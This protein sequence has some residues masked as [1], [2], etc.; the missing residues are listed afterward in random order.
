MLYDK[1]LRLAHAEPETRAALVPLLRQAKGLAKTP[2][3]AKALYQKYKEKHPNTKKGPSDFYEAPAEG[4][5]RRDKT[6][7]ERSKQDEGADKAK[8]VEKKRDR[9]Q[10]REETGPAWGGAGRKR[11]ESR[12]REQA[13]AFLKDADPA[14]VKSEATKILKDM[15][16][17]AADIDEAIAEAAKGGTAQRAYAHSVLQKFKKSLSDK[18]DTA[19]RKTKLKGLADKHGISDKGV[20]SLRSWVK[21][22]PDQSTSEKDKK[23]YWE[24]RPQ[25]NS[26]SDADR[27]RFEKIDKALNFSKK[28]SLADK[29]RDFMQHTDPETRQRILK[30]SPKEF[31]AM[32]AAVM[33]DEEGGG[34]QARV[35]SVTSDWLRSEVLKLAHAVPELRRHVLPVLAG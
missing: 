6:D 25:R 8:K 30:M 9:K 29:K 11:D 21:K 28:K 18:G 24:N 26:L 32:M 1:L 31:E 17:D 5:D 16:F 10:K 34:K 2:E 19:V 3:G 22:N 13:Q 7:K 12:G 15:K 27:K 14:K 33:D 20:S 35:A 23:W 4:E